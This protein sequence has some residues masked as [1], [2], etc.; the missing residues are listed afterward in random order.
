MNGATMA[1]DKFKN[2]WNVDIKNGLKGKAVVQ[3]AS[4]PTE[5]AT[6]TNVSMWLDVY[7]EGWEPYRVQ[8]H[9][10]V[11]MS[12]HPSPGD[13]LPVVVDRENK[14][15]IDIQWGEVKTVDEIMREGGPGQIAGVGNVSM[16]QPQVINLSGAG[17]SGDLNE[18]IQQAMQIAQ[19]AMQQAQE[20]TPPT[21][22]TVSAATP[23]SA[24]TTETPSAAAPDAPSSNMVEERLAALERLAKLRDSGV[25]SDA[26][27]EAEKIKV[28]RGG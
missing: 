1:F 21:E 24:P 15:R 5:S 9:C 23:G 2:F 28:L 20:G 25:L 7:V 22:L 13:T 8:H 14:E 12:K 27:F 10:V 3:S 11:K 16:G 4:M 19:Q 6:A 26:E 17:L 18:Q